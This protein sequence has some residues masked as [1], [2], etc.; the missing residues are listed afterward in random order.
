MPRIVRCVL[1]AL[2]TGL[3]AR[4]V[5]AQMQMPMPMPSAGSPPPMVMTG[6]LDISES[7]NG[8]GTSWLPDDTAVAGASRMDGPWMLMLHGN[9]F[10]QE[11]DV[12]GDRGRHEFGSINWLMGMAERPL[13]GGPLTLQ[14]M[15]SLEALTVGRCGY[16]DL[17]QTGETC[18]GQLLHDQQHPHDLFMGLA[19]SY[20]RALTSSLALELYGG[21]SGE[22]ALGPTAFP[23]RPSA[24]ANPTAPISH[25]W[26][27]STH[28]SFGVAT[29][30]L[31]GRR[32]KVEGSA[33]N[34][35]E[36]DDKRY[37]FDLAPL[38][39]Y[40]ARVWYLPDEHWAVQVSAGHLT[41]LEALPD[42][43]HESASRTTAS[44]T[45][46]RTRPA[47]VWATTVAW[48]RNRQ[49]GTATSALLGET[50]VD[51]SANDQVFAR[52]EWIQKTADELALAPAEAAADAVFTIAKLQVGYTRLLRPTGFLRTGLGGSLG[53]G[54]LPAALESS[55]GG[56][57][58][59]E[60]TIFL[61]VRP[62]R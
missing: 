57:R 28:V 13:A 62:G 7:R 55:Y 16:P 58:P 39:S 17:L 30:G 53:I 20:R 46:H 15:V 35:R 1:F 51:V 11:V 29:A 40:S 34:G 2:L 41:D 4:P 6:P 36:P 48:G 45:Y 14:A 25:H 47:G 61:A 23:H 22:P 10:V 60:F 33:F 37:G 18:R 44:A 56:R 54:L 38:D 43:S 52:G 19:A 42:G 26:L 24:M 9:G 32:W 12:T 27:D 59:L 31:Y 8:S 49:A 50:S 21:P 3:V 5:R